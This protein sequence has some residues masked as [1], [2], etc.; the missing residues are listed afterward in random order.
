MKRKSLLILM[1]LALMSH[2]AAK[3]Q[4]YIYDPMPFD[5]NPYGWTTYNTYGTGNVA[6]RNGKMVFAVLTTASVSG[7]NVSMF[8]VKMC[9][10]YT[11]ERVV[12]VGFTLKPN[13]VTTT[14]SQRF[15]FQVG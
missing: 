6:V 10:L 1:L 2:F 12:K 7:Q 11:E 4:N 8:G 14:T 13:T 9:E 3:A 15:A 5:N